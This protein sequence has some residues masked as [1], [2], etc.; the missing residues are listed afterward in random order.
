LL[1]DHQ[2]ALIASRF[3][4]NLV[5]FFHFRAGKLSG[6]PSRANTSAA[7]RLRL[8]LAPVKATSALSPVSIFPD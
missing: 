3:L 4:G 7:S 2:D 1:S 8:R 6:L 5:Q